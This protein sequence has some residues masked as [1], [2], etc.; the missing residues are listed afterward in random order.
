MSTSEAQAVA[1]RPTAP[2]RFALSGAPTIAEALAE[3]GNR[4]PGFDTVRLLAASAV[5]LHHAIEI[6]YDK[7]YDDWLYLST[8]GY[9][10]LGILAVAI[11][12]VISGFLVTPGLIKTGNV[13]EYLSRRFMRIMPLLA[14]VVVL[15]SLVVGPMISSLSPIAYFSDQ[16]TWAYLINITTSLRLELPGVTNYNGSAPINSPLWTLRFEWLCYLLIAIASLASLLRS[17]AMFAAI[18][19]ACIAANALLFD[20]AKADQALGMPGMLFNLFGYFG[21]G[22][23][24][25]LFA[26][27]VRYSW[28]WMVLAFGALVLSIAVGVPHLF[29]PLLIAYLAIGI[30]LTRM[31]WTDQLSKF[32]LSY[33]IY[34][35][36]VV[37]MTVLMK[38]YAFQSVAAFFIAGLALTCIAAF[39]SWTLIEKPALRHKSL[40][41][42]LARSIL[43]GSQPGEWVLKLLENRAQKS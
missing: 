12:F 15:T 21:A 33:G 7:V 16:Q 8:Q 10:H 24:L 32:D 4:G 14:T 13:L 23:M 18:W 41:A 36:H 27:R 37:V 5:V 19:I 25:F 22:V 31:P 2:S 30:G 26:D 28:A 11:F 34:L 3:H 40:P 43:G 1:S 42:S 29:A 38:I 20:F 6:R 35:M 9:T 39:A 17:R